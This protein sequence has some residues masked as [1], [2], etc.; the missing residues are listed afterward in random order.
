VIEKIEDC[1]SK[2]WNERSCLREDEKEREREREGKRETCR[3]R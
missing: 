2:H 3:E 1:N